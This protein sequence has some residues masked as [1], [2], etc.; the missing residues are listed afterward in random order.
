LEDKIDT[1]LTDT[2]I[3]ENN[4]NGK[5][6]NQNN[7]IKLNNIKEKSTR[8]GQ[9]I[10]LLEGIEPYDIVDELQNTPANITLAQLI[11]ISRVPYIRTFLKVLKRWE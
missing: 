11:G 8:A 9:I 4:T 7:K 2:T 10:K 1:E 5:F 6:N 3:I